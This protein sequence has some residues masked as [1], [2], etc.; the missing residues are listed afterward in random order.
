M[1]TRYPDAM[2]VALTSLYISFTLSRT[3]AVMKHK[4][5]L[6]VS[7]LEHV[8]TQ[9][10]TKR[11]GEWNCIDLPKSIPLPASWPACPCCPAAPHQRPYTSFPES[12]TSDHHLSSRRSTPS[13]SRDPHY[14]SPPSRHYSHP[15][16]TPIWPRHSHT[17]SSS[18]ARTRPS[19][20]CSRTSPC[21]PP[22]PADGR[23]R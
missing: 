16:P 22:S 20:F 2:Q 11:R 8:S 1:K 17:Y 12:A 18:S 7:L 6:V 15:R 21:T 4:L 9:P 3:M 13:S 23:A 14:S 19:R 5:L 10:Q